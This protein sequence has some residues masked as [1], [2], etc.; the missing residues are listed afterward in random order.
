MSV[1][2]SCKGFHHHGRC[3]C[4]QPLQDFPFLKRKA[5]L[6]SWK[7]CKHQSSSTR[8]VCTDNLQRRLSSVKG[9]CTLHWISDLSHITAHV[10]QNS[11]K[12]LGKFLNLQLGC[13]DTY[14]IA[15]YLSIW[16]YRVTSWKRL[17]LS[18]NNSIMCKTSWLKKSTKSLSWALTLLEKLSTAVASIFPHAYVQFLK[19]ME[20]SRE[21]AVFLHVTISIVHS[22]KWRWSVTNC[23]SDKLPE[24]INL[25]FGRMMS[26][27]F[28]IKHAVQTNSDDE[29]NKK[30]KR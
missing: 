29:P 18:L 19:E 16:N 20:F 13:Q 28:A 23:N 2:C 4:S 26:F 6:V 15:E 30:T 5:V 24:S 27:S 7:T 1:V 14:L 22:W 17:P 8:S 25:S 3:S 11:K 9:T 10:L 12:N 21:A